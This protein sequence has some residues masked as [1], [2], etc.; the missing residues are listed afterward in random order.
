MNISILFSECEALSNDIFT[1]FFICDN[2]T[3]SILCL[4]GTGNLFR[5]AA[6]DNFSPSCVVN[7]QQVN[8]E[9]LG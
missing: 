5:V 6:S 1:N 9:R 8:G 2:M 4:K 3:S 7:L